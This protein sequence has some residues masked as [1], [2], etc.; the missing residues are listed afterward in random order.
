MSLGGGGDALVATLV[1]QTER[2]METN[3]TAASHSAR[4]TRR[5]LYSLAA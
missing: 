2:W 3:V 4:A 5:R 1:Q